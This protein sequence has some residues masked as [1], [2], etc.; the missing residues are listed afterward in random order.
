MS[1]GRVAPPIRASQIVH[2]QRFGDLD[3]FFALSENS[4]DAEFSVSWIDCTAR[5]RAPGGGVYGR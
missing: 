5:G 2:S 3:E 4:T 1:V